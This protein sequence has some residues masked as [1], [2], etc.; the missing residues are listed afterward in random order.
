[1]RGLRSTGGEVS[2]ARFGHLFFARFWKTAPAVGRTGPFRVMSFSFG[3]QS[4]SSIPP[5]RRPRRKGNGEPHANTYAPTSIHSK[6]AINDEPEETERVETG[7]DRSTIRQTDSAHQA[8]TTTNPCR[9]TRIFMFRPSEI[10][11]G[12]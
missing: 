5:Q 1:M 11:A 9:K 3:L 6:D 12:D 4:K 10:L 7:Q 2:T 8:R